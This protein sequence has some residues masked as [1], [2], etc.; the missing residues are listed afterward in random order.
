LGVVADLELWLDVLEDRGSHG[1]IALAPE[2]IRDG[3]NMR[4]DAEELPDRDDSAARRPRG[5]G[6][7]APSGFSSIQAISKSLSSNG[8]Q[9]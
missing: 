5:I 4:I 7:P 3:P 1:E 6:A 2:P 9:R 8:V